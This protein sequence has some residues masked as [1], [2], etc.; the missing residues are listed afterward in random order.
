MQ[1]DPRR[2]LVLQAVARHGSVVAAA[3]ALHMTPSGVS[4]HLTALERECGIALVD[5]SRRGGQRPIAFTT[6]GRRLIEHADRLA[7]VLDDVG[8]EVAALTTAAGGPVVVATF[9]TALRGFVTHAFLN[10]RSTHPAIEPRVRD[11][12]ER[13]VTKEVLAGR[14]DLGV[15]EDDAERRRPVPRGLR[16][17]A[18]A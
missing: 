8:A 3:A 5:R 16:Y 17:E 4:Q 9:L 7:E 12:D 13:D 2:L 6:A 11:V 10:L 15:V 1:V 14:V 18:L